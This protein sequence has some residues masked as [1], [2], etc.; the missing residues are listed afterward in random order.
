[1]S[2]SRSVVSDSLRPNGLQFMEF[3]RPE[4][5]SG[6]PFPPP[7]ARVIDFQGARYQYVNLLTCLLCYSS[8]V[9][10]PWH[11]LPWPC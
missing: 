5:W 6:E 9:Q 1:M 7:G 3:S 8:P 2:E 11:Q 10:S 4:Y